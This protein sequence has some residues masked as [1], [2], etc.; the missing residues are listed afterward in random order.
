MWVV[1]VV[2]VAVLLGLFVVLLLR[3]R[4]LGAGGALVCVLFGF[5]LGATPAGPV[6]GELLNASGAWLWSALTAL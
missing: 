4:L 1:S 2:A 6:V 5:T 3:T